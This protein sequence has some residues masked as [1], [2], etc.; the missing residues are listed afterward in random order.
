MALI[1]SI[2][3]GGSLG[4]LSR[5]FVSRFISNLFGML[6][7]VGTLAVNLTGSF[8]VGFI[9]VV[10]DKMIISDEIRVFVITGFLGAFTTFSTFALE[11]IN[12]FREKEIKQGMINILVSNIFGLV[13]A[14]VG[15][16]T[17]G[18]LF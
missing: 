7:P 18:L 3:L 12:L 14:F 8:L 4:A 9:F 5:Y 13:F 6:F 15:I 17:A 16:Y 2:A 10:F 1:L 11:N